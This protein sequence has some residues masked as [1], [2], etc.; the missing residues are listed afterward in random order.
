MGRPVK[1]ATPEEAAEAA[2][3]RASLY[4]QNNKEKAMQN[5]KEYRARKRELILEQRRTNHETIVYS[6]TPCE[7]EIVD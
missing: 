5:Q 4:Y 2:R 1:Y 6:Q 3:Q 7:I